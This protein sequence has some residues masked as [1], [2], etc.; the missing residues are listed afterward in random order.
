MKAPEQLTELSAA[1]PQLAI[2]EGI[3]WIPRRG[4]MERVKFPVKATFDSSRAPQRGE[5]VPDRELKPLDLAALKDRL[6]TVEA[7]VSANDPRAL[8]AKVA[9]LEKALAQASNIKGALATPD[10]AAIK[11]AEDAAFLRG[12]EEGEGRGNIAGQALALTRV[13]N[14]LDALK[15][16][17]PRS[18]VP[19]AGAARLPERHRQLSTRRTARSPP[20][21]RKLRWAPWRPS[22]RPA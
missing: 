3:L 7:E 17:A 8:K 4:V 2:G 18:K 15:V 21:A 16:L 22:T 5:V 20:G 1:M 14:A 6:S 12:V 10:P 9:Q 19:R 13:R 11:R